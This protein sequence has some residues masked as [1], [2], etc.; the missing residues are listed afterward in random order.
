[1]HLRIAGNAA[2]WIA[3]LIPVAPDFGEP[4]PQMIFQE[5]RGNL[6][7]LGGIVNLD[8]VGQIAVEENV[9][10]RRRARFPLIGDGVLVFCNSSKCGFRQFARFVDS[11]GAEAPKRQFASAAGS[12]AIPH[13]EGSRSARQ[14]DDAKA[15]CL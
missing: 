7:R 3:M 5:L 14:R 6:V 1:M 15:P 13:D 8:V 4:R 11:Q 12:I 9:H 10:R 2:H